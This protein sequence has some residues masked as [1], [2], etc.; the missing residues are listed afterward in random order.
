M[1]KVLYTIYCWII[2]VAGFTSFTITGVIRWPFFED[3]QK[4]YYSL[5]CKFI[6]ILFF[7]TGIKVDV[8]GTEHV[9]NENVILVSNHQ[10]LIDIFV[11]MAYFPKQITFFAKKELKH[12]PILGFNLVQM[13]HVLVDREK[14]RKALKQLDIIKEKLIEGKSI[15]IFPE[16]TRSKTG[17]IGPFKKGAFLLA[18]DTQ[19]ALIPCYI[20]GTGKMLPKN[21]F[22][23]TQAKISLHIQPELKNNQNEIDKKAVVVNNI[24]DETKNMLVDVQRKVEAK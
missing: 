5:A 11:L 17:E 10:S 15:I 16:G 13:G 8:H 24:K 18:Y 6:R 3:K 2:V 19:K 12:V 7:L 9:P 22:W 4:D 14:G 21:K 1:I 23:I 20:K